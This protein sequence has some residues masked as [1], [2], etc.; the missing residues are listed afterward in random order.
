MHK[1]NETSFY[2]IKSFT[3]VSFFKLKKIRKLHLKRIR[4]YHFLLYFQCI[5]QIKPFRYIFPQYSSIQTILLRPSS[6]FL[7]TEKGEEKLSPCTIVQSLTFRF[8]LKMKKWSFLTWYNVLWAIFWPL[9]HRLGKTLLQGKEAPC[10]HSC[11]Y[12]VHGFF[13]LLNTT[14]YQKSLPVI[15]VFKIW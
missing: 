6:Y 10:V 12:H 11:V 8:F 1:R 4:G 9:L 2:R 7:T 13:L 15:F 14:K 3:L 5:Q